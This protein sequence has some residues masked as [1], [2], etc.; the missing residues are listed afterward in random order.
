M[1]DKRSFPLKLLSLSLDIVQP[2]IHSYRC[3]KNVAR[4]RWR[5]V[6]SPE[7]CPPGPGVINSKLF[8]GRRRLAMMSD[9]YK[10]HPL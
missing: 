4:T 10:Y 8:R 6:N 3:D 9:L 7:M 1:F 5:L 2:L